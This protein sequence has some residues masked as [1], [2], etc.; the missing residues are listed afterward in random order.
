MRAEGQCHAPFQAPTHMTQK[1]SL[2]ARS[3]T[4]ILMCRK[5]HA[6]IQHLPRCVRGLACT[7]STSS[8]V[9]HT[10]NLSPQAHAHLSSS[11]R[12]SPLVALRWW[13]RLC[14]NVNGVMVVAVKEGEGRAKMCDAPPSSSKSQT[15]SAA[16]PDLV[17]HIQQLGQ[18]NEP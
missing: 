18:T 12:P 11:R 2:A 4:N 13:E 6:H 8:T 16:I 14:G 3:V 7:L 15:L 9:V 10:G 1:G 5:R 17:T